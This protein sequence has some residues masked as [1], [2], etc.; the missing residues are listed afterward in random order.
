MVSVEDRPTN[1]ARVVVL[2]LPNRARLNYRH[3]PDGVTGPDRRLY[4][5]HRWRSEGFHG[6]AKTWLARAVRRGGPSMKQRA[7]SRTAVSIGSNQSSKRRSSASG[8]KAPAE[9]LSLIMACSP[10]RRSK[11]RRCDVEHPGDYA[12]LNSNHPRDRTAA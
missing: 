5:C 9:M 12:T 2:P 6:E 11:A 10:A 1:L 8:C 7:R 3:P 4:Q